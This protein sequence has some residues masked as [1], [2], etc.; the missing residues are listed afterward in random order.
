M[1]LLSKNCSI[2]KLPDVI[3]QYN[4][5]SEE[6]LNLNLIKGTKN[7]RFENLII[8]PNLKISKSKIFFTKDCLLNRTDKIFII[9]NVNG[10]MLRTYVIQDLSGNEIP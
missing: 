9:A 3:N 1:L 4:N 8:Q 5:M 7:S 10:T 6:N 2:D